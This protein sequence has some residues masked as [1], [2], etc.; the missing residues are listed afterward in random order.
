MRQVATRRQLSLSGVRD[1]LTRS[2]LTGDVTP[3]LPGGGSPAKLDT[4]G[5]ALVRTA[6]PHQPESTLQ[7]LCDG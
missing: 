6:I 7:E 2:R 4:T 1:L 5:L 3:T